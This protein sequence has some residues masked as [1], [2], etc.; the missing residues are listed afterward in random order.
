[1]V[2]LLDINPCLVG[3]RVG[4]DVA[5]KMQDKSLGKE[6]NGRKYLQFNNVR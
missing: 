1:M 3:D 5:I 6:G 4:M 2:P